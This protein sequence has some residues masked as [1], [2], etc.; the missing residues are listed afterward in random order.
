MWPDGIQIFGEKYA[1]YFFLEIVNYI[2]GMM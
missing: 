2:S 1:L